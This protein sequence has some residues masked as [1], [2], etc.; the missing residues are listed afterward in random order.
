MAVLDRTK[1]PGAAGE[2]LYQDVV[3]AL[4]ERAAAGGP[5]MPLVVGGRYGLAS[6]EF[7][8]AMARAVLDSLA[9]ET[10][11]NHFTVGIA[12]DVSRTSLAVDA[13][14][15]TEDPDGL[16]A[17]FFGLGSRRHR[18]G[19]QDLGQDRRRGHRPVRPGLLRARLQEVR[20]R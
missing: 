15:S 11:R 1:E 3:C 7:T 6:K 2:P 12:D 16:R 19:Q 14:F 20:A 5:P 4:A 9:A 10:P 18:G 13:A 17:V 8:P